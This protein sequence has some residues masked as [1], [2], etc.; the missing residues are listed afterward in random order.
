MS[1]FIGRFKH[2]LAHILYPMPNIDIQY[3][4]I[5]NLQKDNGDK[6][7]HTEHSFPTLY[8]AS[9]LSITNELV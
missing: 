2:F 1:D 3:M 9:S 5:T 7:L 6:I 4:F 8:N